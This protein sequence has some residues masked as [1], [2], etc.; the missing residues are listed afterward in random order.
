M[1]L[2]IMIPWDIVALQI[3]LII[4]ACFRHRF[5]ALVT[6]ICS[7]L[8]S[9]LILASVVLGAAGAVLAALASIAVFVVGIWTMVLVSRLSRP[10]TGNFVG[11]E[12]GSR[13]AQWLKQRHLPLTAATLRQGT[14]SLESLLS[15]ESL[16]RSARVPGVDAD[17]R[18]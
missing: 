18:E 9:I 3:L 7:A 14:R 13:M 6:M 11:L 1:D 16:S 17:R 12:V 8:T 10:P 5:I 2:S 15:P 4:F